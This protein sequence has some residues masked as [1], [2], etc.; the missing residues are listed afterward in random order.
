MPGPE[1]YISEF[2]ASIDHVLRTARSALR[3]DNKMAYF[4]LKTYRD[5]KKAQALRNAWE[6]KGVHVPPSLIMSITGRCN[7]ACAGCYAKPWKGA[8][9]QELPL[10]RI[11]AI[12]REAEELGVSFMLLAGGEPLLRPEVLRAAAKVKRI[13]FPVF[14]NGMLMD[15]EMAS[16]FKKNR[17]VFPVVSL[18]GNEDFTDTRRGCGTYTRLTSLIGRLGK[19]G[20]FTG[21]SLTVTRKNLRTLTSDEFVDRFLGLG[22]RLF[23]FVEYVPVKSGT[24]GLVITQEQRQVLAKRTEQLRETSKSLFISFPGDEEL[25]GGCLSAGRGFAHIDPFGH[26]EPCPFAPYHDTD[27]K[28]TSLKDALASP[29]LKRIRDDPGMLREVSGGCALWA[30]R[31]WLRGL[32]RA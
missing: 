16:L 26:L 25:Y 29:L 22:A 4:M 9:E 1:G 18:E 21:L 6:E 17:N 23:I 5:Q 7:L 24:E 19:E 14:T 13:V 15:D 31:E 2:N 27:L 30:N 10:E 8:K 28:N 12:M 20:V 11:T 32:T 3:Q